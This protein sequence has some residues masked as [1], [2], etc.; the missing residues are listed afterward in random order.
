MKTKM[1]KFVL[2]AL[3]ASIITAFNLNAQVSPPSGGGGG[4]SGSSDISIIQSQDLARDLGL[5]LGHRGS[6][7]YSSPSIDWNYQDTATGTN[8]VGKYAEDVL[9]QLASFQYNIKLKNTNDIITV[10]AY[11]DDDNGNTLFSGQATFKMG[12]KPTIQ[13]WQQWVPILSNIKSAEVIA[14]K[15]DGTS[16][17]SIVMNISSQGQLLW[18]PGLSGAP[19]GLL[20]TI[21]DD[22]TLTTYRLSKPV[23]QNPSPS[24]GVT[25]LSISGHYIFVGQDIPVI[26]IIAVWNKP[27]A[28]FETSKGYVTFDVRGVVQL[29]DGSTLM[30]RP[31]SME[32]TDENGNNPFQYKLSISGPSKIPLS[33]GKYRVRSFEW[34]LFGTPNTLYTG[35]SY[36]VQATPVTAVEEK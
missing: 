21:S 31:A 1:Q 2:V 7:Y 8:V 11:V 18:Q 10:Y 15:D 29:P 16:G 25:S 33:A 32:L 4:S 3:V 28:Y 26:D 35:P 14:L 13:M 17:Q 36:G 6:I 20:A 30:E 27:T 23:G 22:G 19:N 34:N 24:K 9:S 12:D 5:R